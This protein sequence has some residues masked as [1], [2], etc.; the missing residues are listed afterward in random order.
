MNDVGAVA[1]AQRLLHIV[2]RHQNSNAGLGEFANF[3]LQL[4]NGVRIDGGEWLIKQNE[5]GLRHQRARD[6]Q[7]PSLATRTCP[8]LLLAFNLQAKL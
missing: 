8:R 1:N 2:I 6:F 5:R 3:R 4:L 7:A